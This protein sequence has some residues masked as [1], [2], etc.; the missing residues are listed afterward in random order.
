[1]A[2][3]HGPVTGSPGDPLNLIRI[4]CRLAE[5]LGY[6]EVSRR[7]T[8]PLVKSAGLPGHPELDPDRLRE[9]ITKRIEAFG[10]K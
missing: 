8:T 1:M 2:D 7:D 5:L 10:G 9:Q 4:S 6:P 3:H